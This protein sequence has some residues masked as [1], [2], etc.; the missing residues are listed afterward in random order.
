MGHKAH[1]ADSLCQAHA[2][3][4]SLIHMARDSPGKLEL[5]TQTLRYEA[6]RDLLFAFPFFTMS[7]DSN[8]KRDMVTQ[9]MDFENCDLDEQQTIELFQQL[10]DSRTVWH[11]QGFYGQMAS[12]LIRNGCCQLSEE[13]QQ[14]AYGN[15][16]PSRLKAA[17]NSQ[18]HQTSES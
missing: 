15:T 12:E 16:V 2:L 14:D 7:I 6:M 13:S 9:M 4:H 11:L 8:T 18:A 5:P 1:F 10:I 17:E 3:S